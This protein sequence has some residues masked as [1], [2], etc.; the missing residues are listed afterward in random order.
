M[1]NFLKIFKFEKARKLQ[2]VKGINKYNNL[3]ALETIG[4]NNFIL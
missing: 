1:E 4:K 3:K 2:D